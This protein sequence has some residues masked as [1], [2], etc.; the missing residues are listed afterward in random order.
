M[1]HTASADDLGIK[2]DRRQR[3]SLRRAIG[4]ALNGERPMLADVDVALARHHAVWPSLRASAGAL[5]IADIARAQMAMVDLGRTVTALDQVGVPSVP[6]KGGALLASGRVPLGGRHMDDLDVLVPAQDAVMALRHLEGVGFVVRDGTLHDG[7]PHRE[8]PTHQ[9]PMMVAPGGTLLELHT[10]THVPGESFDDVFGDAKVADVAYAMCGGR[11]VMRVPSPW[12]LL[13]QV[14]AHVLLHH[15][16][17]ARLWPRH[18]FDMVALA[19]VS[20]E[21]QSDPGH[22]VQHARAVLEGF[23]DPRAPVFHRML[24]AGL[25]VPEPGLEQTARLAAVGLRAARALGR[26]DVA[27]LWPDP[28]HL[29]FTGDLRSEG[30]SSADLI[31]ARLRRL[32]RLLLPSFAR[33]GPAGPFP[34]RS[35]AEPDLKNPFNGQRSSTMPNSESDDTEH[36]A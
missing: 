21:N 24:A 33:L 1:T 13:R 6:L 36:T 10:Q 28:E 25:V 14:C 20:L 4:H 30:T 32:R 9:M 5:D 11:A 19:N 18:L 29:R 15:G 3:Q 26:G 2:W 8:R 7:T 34:N 16:G 12:R 17:E 27:V 35:G 23:V 31:R 22:V